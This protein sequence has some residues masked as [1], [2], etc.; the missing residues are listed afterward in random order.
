MKKDATTEE[1]IK[2]AAKEVFLAK[3]FA[4]CSSREIAKAAGENVALVNYY[5]RSKGQLFELIFKSA[6]EDFL[7]SMIHV[8]NSE[9]SLEQKMRIFIEREFEFLTKHPELPS[10]II[11]EMNREEGCAVG[12]HTIHFEKIAETGIFNECIKAQQEGTMREINLISVIMLIMSN[13]QYPTMAKNLMKNIHQ[14]TDEEYTL[15][16]KTH[17]SHVTEMLVNYL[18]PKNNSTK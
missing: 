12:E 15:Q 2:A 11:N 18:F 6:M 1:K 14:L 8:F 5:F 13:C 17:Q 16:L 10:F 9:Q 4:G 3:G 7:L